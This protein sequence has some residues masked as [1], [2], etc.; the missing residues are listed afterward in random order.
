MKKIPIKK[1]PTGNHPAVVYKVKNRKFSRQLLDHSIQGILIFASVFVAFWLSEVRESKKNQAIV[2]NA[3]ENIASEMRYNHQQMVRTFNY[4]YPILLQL[5]S[6]QKNHPQMIETLKISQLSGWRGLGPG[7]PLLR[8]S[9]YQTML[10]SGV[11]KDVPLSIA[12]Y[13]AVIYNLQTLIERF[14]NA[15]I[16]SVRQHQEANSVESVS[17]SFGF[18]FEIIPELMAMYQYYGLKHL[19]TYGYNLEIEDGMLKEIVENNMRYFE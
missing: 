13:L 7:L 1:I 14:D 8:S 5:D 10:T 6:I 18:Y 2:T 4:H 15:F 17:Y 9:A 19:M 16:I 11:T 12:N 3:L